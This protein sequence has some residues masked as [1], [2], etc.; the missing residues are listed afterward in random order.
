MLKPNLGAKPDQLNTLA[1]TKNEGLIRGEI[2]HWRFQSPQLLLTPEGWSAPR[3]SFTNDPFTPAQ[4]WV[5][6]RNVRSEQEADGTTVIR[7]K[8]NRLLLENKLPLPLPKTFRFSPEEEQEVSN[9]WSVLADTQD[10]DG[11]FLQYQLPEQTLFGSTRLSVRPQFMLERAFDGTTNTYPAPTASAGSGDVV[12]DNTT[13]DLFGV[14]ALWSGPV[15][16]ANF[17]LEADISSFAPPISPTPPARQLS[18][19]SR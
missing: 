12:Q 7:S 8:S 9:R 4:S 16:D 19:I 5:D 1:A 2:T 10:R 6:M 11:I 3:I 18:G 14:K 17:N 15:G 13:G